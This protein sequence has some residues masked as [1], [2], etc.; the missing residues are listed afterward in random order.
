M[1][2]VCIAYTFTSAC[3]DRNLIQKQAAS[4]RDTHTTPALSNL[5]KC[6]EN[7]ICGRP[8]A[9]IASTGAR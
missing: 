8:N 1:R 5:A 3:C 7:A 4:C 6:I 2:V 9:T